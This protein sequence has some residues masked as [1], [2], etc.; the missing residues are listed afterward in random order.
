MFCAISNRQKKLKLNSRKKNPVHIFRDSKKRICVNSHIFVK[1]LLLCWEFIVCGYLG[2]IPCNVITG[3]GRT[4][5][6]L[7]N[8]SI[9]GN[10]QDDY[11]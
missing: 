2:D 6:G 9:V 3:G 10:Y 11:W 4:A 1:F 7:A 5:E 8:R